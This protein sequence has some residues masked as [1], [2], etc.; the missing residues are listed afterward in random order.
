M[1]WLG[2]KAVVLTEIRGAFGAEHFLE[3]SEQP[4]L[5]RAGQPHVVAEGP[6]FL[7]SDRV[8]F[9]TGAIIPVDGGWAPSR[10]DGRV[11]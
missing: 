1:A 10:L 5:E 4:A 6:A 8:S 3:M 7:N 11:R 9:L 2:S